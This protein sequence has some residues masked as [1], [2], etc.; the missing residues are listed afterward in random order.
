MG[1]RFRITVCALSAVLLL[2]LAGCAFQ[3]KIISGGYLPEKITNIEEGGEFDSSKITAHESGEV[4][5][6]KIE[7]FWV[8][9]GIADEPESARSIEGDSAVVTDKAITLNDEKI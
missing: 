1:N 8:Y 3:G 2:V 9:E 6:E 7:G 4:T 5:L